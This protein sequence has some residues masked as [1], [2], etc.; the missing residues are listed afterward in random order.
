MSAAEGFRNCKAAKSAWPFHPLGQITGPERPHHIVMW[1]DK[2]RHI[3][4]FL[5]GFSDTYIRCHSALENYGCHNGLPFTDII[6]IIA[7]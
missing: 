1:R 5:K 6:E 3:Q 2:Y 7:D 4:A